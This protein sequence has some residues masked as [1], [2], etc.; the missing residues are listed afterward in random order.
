MF[1]GLVAF[2]ITPTDS[3]GTVNTTT[4]GR[5]IERLDIPA[6]IRLVRWGVQGPTCI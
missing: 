6:L 5:I 4:L 3:D 1:E 2:P